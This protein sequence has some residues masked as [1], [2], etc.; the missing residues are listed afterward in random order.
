MPGRRTSRSCASAGGWSSARP[1][2]ATAARPTTWSSPWIR[3]W[4]SGPGSTRRRG[5]AWPALEP[6][7]DDGTLAGRAR[8]RRRLWLGH[9]G[10]R[11]AAPRRPSAVGVDIDPIAIEA[12]AANARR[13]GLDPPGHAPASGAC[14]AATRRSTSSS[15]TSSPASSCRSPRC[16]TTS[17]DRAARSSRR[18]SSSTA[19]PRSGARSRP[20]G[21]GVEDRSAEGDWVALRRS[22]RP[23]R[24]S[25]DQ[26]YNRSRCRPR[27]SR[28]LLVVHITLAI[29]LFLPS[30]LLPFTLRTR[31]ATVDS[32]SRVGAGAP[33][34][35][36]AR[37]GRHR[38]RT[39]AHRSGL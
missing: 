26:P 9:P 37:H 28:S 17:C 8:P 19:R 11:R 15:P 4:P 25:R 18:A 32:D 29:S 16:S 20:P 24:D 27:C 14:R 1:G 23:D 35:A 33:L 22:A 30:I 34:G 39:G 38:G 3:A 5:C 36:V 31:R 13:N 2:V 12:T 7:A 6:L 21:L 10:D